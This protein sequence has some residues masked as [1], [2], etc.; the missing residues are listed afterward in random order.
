MMYYSRVPL[1][2]K[3]Q[4]RENKTRTQVW[5]AHEENLGKRKEVLGLTLDQ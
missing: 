1:A 3:E 4:M 2:E 5:R